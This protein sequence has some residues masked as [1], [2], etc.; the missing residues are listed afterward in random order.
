LGESVRRSPVFTALAQTAVGDLT[1]FT[2]EAM[3]R[4]GLHFA[5]G[6]TLGVA[7]LDNAIGYGLM[8]RKRRPPRARQ[9][10]PMGSAGRGRGVLSEMSSKAL[11]AEYGIAAPA[12]RLVTSAEAAVAAALELGYPVVVKVQ[13][14]DIAHKT[15]AGGVKL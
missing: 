3:E 12:E 9:A 13:S 2:R 4:H 11:L 5:N 6:L 14:P 15:D 1:P 10:R 7:A 8:R